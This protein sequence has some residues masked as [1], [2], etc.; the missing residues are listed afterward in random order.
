MKNT[1][2]ILLSNDLTSISQVTRAG[3]TI[4]WL[5]VLSDW[6][7]ANLLGNLLEETMQIA[8]FISNMSPAFQNPKIIP[9]M[10]NTN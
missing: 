1:F 10:R 8:L 3:L 6:N 2:Q 5:T 4:L 7:F 9:R